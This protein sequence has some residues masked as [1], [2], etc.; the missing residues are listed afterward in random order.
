MN[1]KELLAIKAQLE[2][3]DE[4][5]NA[6]I[7]VL[8]KTIDH[9]QEIEV[10]YQESDWPSIDNALSPVVPKRSTNLN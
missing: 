3:H 5:L 4:K 1:D 10:A 7:V 6:L 2:E 9:L 8:L